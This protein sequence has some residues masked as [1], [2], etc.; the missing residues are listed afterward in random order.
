MYVGN[1]IEKMYIVS[2]IIFDYPVDL[3]QESKVIILREMML[4]LRNFITR[5]DYIIEIVEK[6]STKEDSGYLLDELKTLKEI[7]QK[8]MFSEE[9]ILKL[10]A[11]DI[12]E[13]E[14]MLEMHDHI[15]EMRNFIV[16]NEE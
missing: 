1:Y 8:N 15:V 14:G 4:T 3:P 6:A 2:N 16:A 9:Q 10:S 7:Q 5:L 11:A 12:F 13:N